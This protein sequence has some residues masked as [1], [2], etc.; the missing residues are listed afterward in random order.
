M[1]NGIKPV[2]QTYLE[3]TEV[4]HSIAKKALDY[5]VKSFTYLQSVHH[6]KGMNLISVND[7]KQ[8]VNAYS[9]ADGGKLK[10]R[11]LLKGLFKE[12]FSGKNCYAGAPYLFIDIDVKENENAHLLHPETN[13]RF[14]NELKKVCVI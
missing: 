3:V 1:S 14:F 10:D 12:G 5:S 7:L 2:V 9:N 11:C 4:K 6:A 13:Q 8:L